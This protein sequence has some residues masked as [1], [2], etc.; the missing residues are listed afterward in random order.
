MAVMIY[1]ILSFYKVPTTPAHYEGKQI[2]SHPHIT[3]AYKNTDN[4]ERNR[5]HLSPRNNLIWQS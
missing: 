5:L 3:D 2:P 4:P 1:R